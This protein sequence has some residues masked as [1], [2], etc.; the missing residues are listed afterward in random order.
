MRTSGVP[1]G[2]EREREA[3]T[4]RIRDVIAKIERLH[5]SLGRHLRHS[6]R[7]GVF[8]SYRPDEPPAWHVKLDPDR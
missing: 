6:I 8:C 5:P 2:F 1:S 7:T 4:A 3:A